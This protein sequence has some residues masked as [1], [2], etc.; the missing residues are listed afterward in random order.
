MRIMYA[1]IIIVIIITTG[2]I[3]IFALTSYH[4]PYDV[5]LSMEGLQETYKIGEQIDFFVKIKGYGNYCNGPSIIIAKETNR[6]DTVWIGG[7]PEFIGTNCPEHDINITFQVDSNLEKPL[8]IK[9]AG[10]YVVSVQFGNKSIEKE[11]SIV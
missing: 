6:S 9:Q 3:A 7:G 5:N 4:P 11:F 1:S 10:T 8:I 2:F